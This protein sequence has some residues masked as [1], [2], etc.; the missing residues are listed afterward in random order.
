VKNHYG[1]GA[2]E[3]VRRRRRRRRKI[4]SKNI[5]FPASRIR[6]RVDYNAARL[7]SSAE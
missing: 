5:V 6:T 7:D 3:M 2:I 1:W 4:M